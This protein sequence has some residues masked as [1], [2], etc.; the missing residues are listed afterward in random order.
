MVLADGLGCAFAAGALAELS[1][2]GVAWEGA[3]GAGLGAQ[4]ALLAVVGEAEEGERRWRRGAEAGLPLLTSAVAAVHQRLGGRAPVS[5]LPD[6]WR[7][8]GWLDDAG[9]DEHLAPELALLARLGPAGTS[10]AVAVE[11]LAGGEA[12]WAVLDGHEPGRDAFLFRAAATFAGGWGPAEHA[13]ALVWGGIAALPLFPPALPTDG[14]DVVC[15]FPVPA[16]GRP[17]LG[18]SLFELVQ[19]RDE[20]LAAERVRGWL[21][22]WAGTPYRV[23]APTRESWEGLGRGRGDLG[24]EY[25]LPWERN[26]QLVPDLLAFGAAAARTTIGFEQ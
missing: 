15:G 3:A 5:L 13:G 4:L 16:V 14:W 18:Q 21:E 8:T 26:S 9:V 7:M 6:A 12:T 24:V 22:A 2:A 25:P 11:D 23:V 10:F 17:G 1:R 20:R 19:R